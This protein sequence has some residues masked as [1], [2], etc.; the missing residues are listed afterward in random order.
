MT[1]GHIVWSLRDEIDQSVNYTSIYHTIKSAVR[2]VFTFCDFGNSFFLAFCLVYRFMN[3]RR[4]Y[5]QI[6]VRLWE[7]MPTILPEDRR[8][9]VHEF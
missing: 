4:S 7:T 6:L 3:V 2:L 1:R 8:I 5:F 9:R